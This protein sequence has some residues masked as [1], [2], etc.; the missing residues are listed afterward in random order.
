M[1]DEHSNISAT[2]TVLKK[3]ETQSLQMPNTLGE[4]NLVHTWHG[5]VK[6]IEFHRT[7]GALLDTQI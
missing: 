6:S 2:R 1:K 3:N 7:K 4:I 5:F